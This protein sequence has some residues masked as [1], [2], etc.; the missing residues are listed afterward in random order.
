MVSPV[1]RLGIPILALSLLLLFGLGVRRA[2]QRL[3]SPPGAALWRALFA[4]SVMAAWMALIGGLAASGA[5]AHFDRRPPP[6]MGVFAGTIVLALGAALS[7]LG[8]RLAGGLPLG[9]LVGFQAFRLPLELLMHRAAQ[10]G[11]MPSVMSFGGYNYDIVTGASAALLGLWFVIGRPSRAAVML[12][13]ALGSTLLLVITLIAAAAMPSFAA[14][15]PDQLNVWVTRF[16]YV[17]MAIM[18]G[19]A[20]FG[21]VLVFRRLSMEAAAPLMS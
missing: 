18:V 2:E 10:D 1:V 17:W 12:W 3:G 9:A 5:L 11:L 16:P 7:P 21:H 6:M 14:F 15:G 4:G 8:R 19:S 20:F 13:N